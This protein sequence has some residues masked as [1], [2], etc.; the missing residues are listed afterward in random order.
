MEKKCLACGLPLVRKEKERKEDNWE[1]KR[2]RYCNRICAATG[3]K[4]PTYLSCLHCG[5]RW[6]AM[7]NKNQ[8][9][10]ERNCYIAH[11]R[12]I[13]SLIKECRVCGTELILGVNVNIS[14]VTRG[15]KICE[16][17]EKLRKQQYHIA[18]RDY[19]LQRNRVF[20]KKNKI[21]LQQ[22]RLLT[23]VRLH[24]KKNG[25]PFNPTYPNIT[26]QDALALLIFQGNKCYVCGLLADKQKRHMSL[27]H[28][29]ITGDIRGY[30]CNNCN[31]TIIS[32]LEQMARDGLLVPSNGRYYDAIYNPPMK[33]MME[34]AIAS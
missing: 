15:Q 21:M 1:F 34:Q 14:H 2:R 30:A 29:H 22:R 17:C 7:I 20:R 19:I 24:C 8:Q 6:L 23:G 26:N 10:C 32:V 13:N 18:N 9:F 12:M 11:T 25:I 33:R 28:N 5:K 3:A 4:K 27:D 31:I 16:P